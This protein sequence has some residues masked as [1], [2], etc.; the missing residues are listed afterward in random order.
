MEKLLIHI[1]FGFIVLSSYA[2]QSKTYYFYFHSQVEPYP[3]GR[4][5]NSDYRDFF[6]FRTQIFQ[7]SFNDN[8]N[9]DNSRA[10]KESLYNEASSKFRKF[11]VDYI[12]ETDP[13]W[14]SHPRFNLYNTSFVSR[15]SLSEIQTS[16]ANNDNF[17][18]LNYNFEG[19]PTFKNYQNQNI[20]S[21]NN[22]TSKNIG[23][24]SSV[25]SNTSTTSSQNQVYF[26]A[27]SNMYTTPEIE[28]IKARSQAKYERNMEK[29]QVISNAVTGL[30]NYF[31]Q[32]RQQRLAFEERQRQLKAQEERK[33][34]LFR[35]QASQYRS[36]YKKIISARKSFLKQLKLKSTLD[37][38]GTGFKPLYIYFAYVPKNYDYYYENISYPS[39]L[40]FKIN[41]NIDVKFS[42]VF[43]FFPYSN[44]Q[45]PFI[46]DIKNKILYDHFSNK[47]KDYDVVFFQW[48]NSVEDV[49]SSLKGNLN[50]AVNESYFASAIPSNNNN[51]VFLNTKINASQSKDYWTGQ[52]V[53]TKNTKK[54]DYFGND[55]KKTKPKKD[56]WKT[57]KKKKTVKD[58]T[59]AKKKKVNYWDN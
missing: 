10:F 56:Y 3:E 16:H 32:Q 59:N 17:I 39:T 57:S 34:E 25:S 55:S 29:V 12:S 54:V 40:D 44:G 28:A 18:K 19:C 35:S 51:I 7:C 22:T 38:D 24:I 11:L 52:K 4:K 53:K 31:E 23:N 1:I 21:A 45:Y 15:E 36:E 41:Q 2:Q 6:Q 9:N 47:A 5:T 58:S 50:K 37:E 43:G 42:P 14:A 46:S 13:A 20:T 27:K 8:L 49:V 30:V 33:K 48:K 26:D